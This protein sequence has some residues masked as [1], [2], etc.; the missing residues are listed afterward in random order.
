MITSHRRERTCQNYD[1]NSRSWRLHPA[2]SHLE[3]LRRE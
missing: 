1:Y 2:E 3:A